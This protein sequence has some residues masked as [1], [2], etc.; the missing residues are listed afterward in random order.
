MYEREREREREGD[1]QRLNGYKV[2]QPPSPF[3]IPQSATQSFESAL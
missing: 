1:R 2:P 3:L